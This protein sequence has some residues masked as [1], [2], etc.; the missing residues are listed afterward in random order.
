MIQVKKEK[1][2]G[3]E[4]KEEPHV[5][6]SPSWRSGVL[7]SPAQPAL[8]YIVP[9]MSVAVVTIAYRN[10]ELGTAFAFGGRG[11]E[12]EEAEPEGSDNGRG[13]PG[14]GAQ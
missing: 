1:A 8:L 5:K 2:D 11:I 13:E 4:Q 10:A 14:D 3:V 12:R 7:S 6:R 9:S